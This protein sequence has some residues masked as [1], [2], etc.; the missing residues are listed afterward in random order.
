VFVSPGPFTVVAEDGRFQLNGLAP[1][2]HQLRAWHPRFPP[3]Q[4]S[5]R[6]ADGS[7]AHLDL[8]MG[9]DQRDDVPASAPADLP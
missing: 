2:E 5:L 7:T 1:G 9:V 6:I 3:A 4:A 8:D